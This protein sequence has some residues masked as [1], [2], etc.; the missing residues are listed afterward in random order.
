M[1]G[2][3]K[4]E[5]QPGRGQPAHAQSLPIAVGLD[6]PVQYVWDAHLLLLIDQQRNVIYSFGANLY[7]CHS[8]RSLPQFR[9]SCKK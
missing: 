2:F 6:H 4:N 1:V 8:G 5:A 3:G 7:F 9:F